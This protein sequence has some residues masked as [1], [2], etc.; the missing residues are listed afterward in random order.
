M[1]RFLPDTGDSVF[2]AIQEFLAAEPLREGEDIL[3]RARVFSHDDDDEAG[4][5]QPAALPDA[6]PVFPAD[7]NSH[8]AFSSPMSPKSATVPPVDLSCGNDRLPFDE[9]MA[10]YAGLSGQDAFA[11]LCGLGD[12]YTR[13]GKLRYW[14]LSEYHVEVGKPKKRMSQHYASASL[15]LSVADLWEIFAQV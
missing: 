13:M 4:V 2:E 15:L 6:A 3:S 1:S 11:G 7:P 10:A 8:I 9:T 14:F 12:D 5:N